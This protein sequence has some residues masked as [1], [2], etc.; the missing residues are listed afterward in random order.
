MNGTIDLP[1][2]ILDA[3]GV[4][5]RGLVAAALAARR[6]VIAVDRD[7]KALATLAAAHPRADLTTLTGAAG[8]D[9][10]GAALAA[11]LRALQRPLGG[12]FAAVDVGLLRGRLLDL[13]VARSCRQFEAALAPQLAAARHLLPLL[14]EGGRGGGYVMIGGPGGA[15]PWA[16][17]GHRSMIEAALRMLAQVLHCE[18]RP[19]GVRVQLLSVDTPAWGVHAGLP[20]TDWPSALD[21]GQQALRLL[22]PGAP[23]SA[24]IDFAPVRAPAAV[25]QAPPSA[26]AF[27]SDAPLANRCLQDARALLDTLTP[28]QRNEVSP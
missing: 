17:Y 14:A 1:V 4:I 8:G 10:G 22:A 25:V 28:S 19:L 24:V 2:V 15:H 5:G 12:I 18:A 26:S 11:A 3:A 16:G 21:I 23:T 27:A 7:A 13:P 20:R 6:A 9:A